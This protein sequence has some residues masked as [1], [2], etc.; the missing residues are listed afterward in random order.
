VR[1]NSAAESFYLR[2]D[3]NGYRSA[4]RS[5][6]ADYAKQRRSEYPE[7]VREQERR[8]AQSERRRRWR[9]NYYRHNSEKIRAQGRV[10]DAVGRGRLE[11]RPCAVCGA[12]KSDAHHPDYRRPLEVIWLCRKHHM[13]VHGSALSA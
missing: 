13:M 6:W 3:G 2:A 4:C 1:L 12:E 9:E 8:F 7:R 5:C 10:R 11:Q